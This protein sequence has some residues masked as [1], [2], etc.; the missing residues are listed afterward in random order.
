M[1]F[2]RLVAGG[3]C[4]ALAGALALVGAA[5]S[6]GAEPPER[7]D[8]VLGALADLSGPFAL[9]SPD[10]IDG[11]LAYFGMVN[12]RGGIGG[13]QIRLEIRDTGYDPATHVAAYDELKSEVSAFS[14][15]LGSATTAA[16]LD[17]L[18]DDD[19]LAIP[20]SWV[21]HW[22]EVPNLLSL[23]A[24]YCTEAI[25]A[26]GTLMEPGETM[27]IIRFPGEYGADAAAGAHYG[28]AQLGVDV[29]SDV[30]LDSFD[31]YVEAITDLATLQPDWAY[32]ATSPGALID[33][34]GFAEQSGYTG[35]WTGAAPVWNPI[36]MTTPVAPILEDRFVISAYTAAWGDDVRGMDELIDTTSAA[37][38]ARTPSDAFVIGWTQ[39][40]AM[41]QVL[42][43]AADSGEIAPVDVL[44]A[45]QGGNL[46]FGELTPKEKLGAPERN[47][48]RATAFYRPSLDAFAASQGVTTSYPDLLAS[49]LLLPLGVSALAAE[50]D[51]VGACLSPAP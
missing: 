9:L 20:L 46:Q 33:L 47:L 7:D 37:F 16:I 51:A 32:L 13:R 50:A 43:R 30:Q 22:A 23:Q 18:A 27:A 4:I 11:Q 3:T 24:S 41:T 19:M 12:E 45:A 2:R 28:A 36:V 48:A 34:V 42:Q 6:A 49:E 29:V 44:M 10:L 1:G 17:R 21:S 38:A 25:N 26:V 5:D 15:S 14:V 31:A 35:N 8:I 39:A 40:Q